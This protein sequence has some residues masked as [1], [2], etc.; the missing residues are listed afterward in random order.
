MLEAQ[1]PA[2][3]ET[4]SPSPEVDAQQEIRDLFAKAFGPDAVS[5][6]IQAV[7]ERF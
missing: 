3:F 4:K 2:V 5:A 1:D 7:K 6:L